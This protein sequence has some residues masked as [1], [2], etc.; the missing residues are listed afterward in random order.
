MESKR[1][2]TIRAFDGSLADA[3]RLLVSE[4]AVFDEC[5]Y[6]AEEIQSMLTM[7]PQRAWLALA[8]GLAVGFVIAFPTAGLSGPRWEIDLLGVLPTWRGRGLATRLIRVASTL[9]ME[10]ARQ[11]RAVVAVDNPASSRAFARAGFRL[12]PET[13]RLLIYRPSGL[14]PREDQKL[15]SRSS[16]GLMIKRTSR[17]SEA[18]D[19]L[20]QPLT[21]GDN[22]AMTLLLAQAGEQPAGYAE[23]IEV[24]T[25]LYRGAW[26]ESLQTQDS[27]V[28]QALVEA[29]VDTAVDAGLNEIGAMVPE[30]NWPLRD[31]LLARGFRSLGD[32][33]WHLARLPLPGLARSSPAPTGSV[34]VLI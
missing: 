13:C 22:P 27:S 10:M 24:E 14:A 1:R 2:I 34:D 5:P 7:G 6:N 23:L 15:R 19:W 17:V 12:E 31:S 20:P 4:R 28:R 11:A 8:G 3:Q 32:F 18:A 25:L 9:G 29:A 26:I 16:R 33:R 21:L 30:G